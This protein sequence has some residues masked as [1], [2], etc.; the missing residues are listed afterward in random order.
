[1]DARVTF[2]HNIYLRN[3]KFK[4]SRFYNRNQS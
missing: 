3:Q 2:I 1:M 4:K